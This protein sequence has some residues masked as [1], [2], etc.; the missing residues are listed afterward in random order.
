MKKEKET[1]LNIALREY[2]IEKPNTK[3]YNWCMRTGLI[4]KFS[5]EEVKEAKLISKTLKV[6]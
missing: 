4:H 6:W 3:F 2:Q 5:D 1:A